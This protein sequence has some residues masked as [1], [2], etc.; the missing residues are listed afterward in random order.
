VQTRA[1]EAKCDA[2]NASFTAA[3]AVEIE[4]CRINP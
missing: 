1:G 4:G 3:Q 2:R